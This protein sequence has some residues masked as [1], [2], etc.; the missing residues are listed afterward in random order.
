MGEAAVLLGVAAA[1]GIAG[2]V[3]CIAMCGGIASIGIVGDRRAARPLVAAVLFHGAR[4]SSYAAL[5]AAFAAMGGLASAGI[6]GRFEAAG[7]VLAA[8]LMLAL[9]IRILVNRDVFRLE[10]LGARLFRGAS[11]VWGALVRVRGP[12]RHAALGVLWGLM[13]CGLVYSMLAVAAATGRPLFGASAMAVFGLGTVPALI[14]FTLGAATLAP[15]L[16]RA[17]LRLLAGVVVLIGALWTGL[18]GLVHRTH[19][20]PGH[21]EATVHE[22]PAPQSASAAA[23]ASPARIQVPLR[24]SAEPRGPVPHGR[25]DGVGP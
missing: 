6:P 10:R 9:A 24:A 22:S 15:A 17:R 3:H 14:G 4:I 13:P 12:W 11:P 23:S 25:H 19:E 20:H 7:R 1:A 8:S 21:D 18:G 16:P 2:S 5:G